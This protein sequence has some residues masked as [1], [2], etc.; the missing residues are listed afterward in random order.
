MSAGFLLNLTH[1]LL[2]L[3]EPILKPKSKQLIEVDLYYGTVAST[4]DSEQSVQTTLQLTGRSDSSMMVKKRKN[5]KFLSN[6]SIVMGCLVNKWLISDVVD[7]EI[8]QKCQSCFYFYIIFVYMNILQ[9]WKDV[10]ISNWIRKLLTYA[11]MKSI[12]IWFFFPILSNSL[13]SFFCFVL[14]VFFSAF[15]IWNKNIWL[16]FKIVLYFYLY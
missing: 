16:T 3:C 1:V 9:L 13:D 8:K 12:S 14:L 5:G 2:K 11:F 6:L 7:K 4:V 10:K 15:K